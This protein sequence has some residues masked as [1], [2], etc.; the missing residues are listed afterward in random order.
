MKPF[1]RSDTPGAFLYVRFEVKR[2]AYL[3]CTKT[4]NV[5]L[6]KK[7]AAEY[8]AAVI[9]EAFHLID[10]MKSRSGAATFQQVIDDYK[11]FPAPEDKT[12]NMNCTALVQVLKAAGLKPSDTIDNTGAAMAIAW[13][14][15]GRKVD[16]PV[17][18]INR[19]LRAARSLFSKRAM[20]LYAPGNK[21]HADR[22]RDLFTV[23]ALRE[24]ETRPEL[25]TPEADAAAHKGLQDR[26]ECFRAYLLAKFG[27]LRSGEA[28]AAKKSWLEVKEDG[29]GVLY[30]G[31]REFVA[32]SRKWRPVALAP[33][34]VT[35]LMASPVDSL[36]GQF[37]AKTLWRMPT[38][39]R[40]YGFPAKKTYHSLRRL[41]GSIVY[42]TQG[43]RQARDFCGHSNQ[44]V[45]DKHYARSM[46]V[47]VAI[48]YAG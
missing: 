48:P 30:V 8:R 17:A 40:T 3:W 12:R 19:V 20:M 33:E 2:K 39:L 23:P 41:A 34:V 21:P 32:K 38:I 4:D 26:P 18:T 31:G 35:A 6:A 1:K 25:P 10:G 47:P 43:P 13:Q 37:P 29:S 7:R 45:T 15:H 9:S 36:V 11:T 46:D 22:V 16:M 44:A 27:G 5:A 28:A 14:K 24:P 42:T